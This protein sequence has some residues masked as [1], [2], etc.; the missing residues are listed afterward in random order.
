V[1]IS[2]TRHTWTLVTA[3]G[4]ANDANTRNDLSLS[5]SCL[6]S[7]GYGKY[8]KSLQKFLLKRL[9]GRKVQLIPLEDTGVTG[10]FEVTVLHSGRVLHSKRTMAG[11][12]KA[13]SDRE[14]LAI[15]EQIVELL[16][17]KAAAAEAVEDAES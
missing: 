13:E 17:E 5:V 8:Y 6:H 12:G 16:H 3:W 7:Q 14:R 11:H 10:N 4:Q 9:Y 15:L 1:A 2:R